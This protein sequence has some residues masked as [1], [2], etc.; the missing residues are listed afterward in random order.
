MAAVT[1]DLEYFIANS[2]ARKRISVLVP[3]Y[4]L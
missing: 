1:L 4:R 3:Q 2:C